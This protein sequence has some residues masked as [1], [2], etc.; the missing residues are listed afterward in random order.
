MQLFAFCQADFQF[1]P[2]VFPVH[3]QRHNGV[4]FAFDGADELIEFVTIQ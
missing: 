2:A 1:G 4:A 3:G